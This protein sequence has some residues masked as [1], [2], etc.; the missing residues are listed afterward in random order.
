MVKKDGRREQFVGEKMLN[1]LVG[2]CEK[3]AVGYEEVEEISNHVECKLREDGDAEICC[4]ERG[5]DVMKRVMDVE[6]V[7]YV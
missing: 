4:R 3:R 7:W 5:E 2:C 6:E 1:G